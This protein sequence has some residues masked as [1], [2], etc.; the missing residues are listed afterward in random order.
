MLRDLELWAKYDSASI[1][2]EGESGTGKTLLARHIHEQSSRKDQTFLRVDLGAI[3]DQLAASEL[4]GHLKGAFTGADARRDG[5]FVE[6]SGGTLFI[7]EIGKASKRVQ[8]LLLHAMEYGEVTPVGSERPVRFDV[9]LVLAT[10]ASLDELVKK[11]QFLPD[12]LYRIGC[13]RAAVPP[14]RKRREDI[15]FLTT[16]IVHDCAHRLGYESSSPPS[17]DDQLLA[18]LVEAPWEGNVR[19]LRSTLEYL[20]VNAR[21]SPVLSLSHCT[22]DLAPLAEK[23]SRRDRALLDVKTFGSISA[24]ARQSGSSRST[25]QRLINQ[26]PDDPDASDSDSS[27]TA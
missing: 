18:A 16:S 20:L 10:N 12:L 7:D 17:V 3:E 19:A 13:F 11:E 26:K 4:F 23:L 5:S 25:I 1:L 21:Q 6:A 22:G 24:A 27:R 14:L 2:L 8:R 15:P 9:R